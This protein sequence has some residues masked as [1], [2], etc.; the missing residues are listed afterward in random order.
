[1]QLEI[2]MALIGFAFVSSITPGPNNLMLL[3][4]GAN[5]GFAKTLPHMFGI[6]S[7]FSVLLICVGVGLGKMLEYYPPAFM[8]LKVAGGSYLLF[9]AY[10]IATSGPIGEAENIGKPMTFIQAA[11]FQWVNP[12]AWVMAISSMSAYT[13]PDQ[14][15]LTV[16]VI[17]L[18]FPLVN[19]PSVTCWAVFGTSMKG[20]LQNRVRLKYFNYLMASLL[21]ISLWPMLR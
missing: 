13:S 3:S 11:L 2:L 6:S 18:V 9:L 12:K 17:A 15:T 19:L 14:Y 7:G 4:S 16:F 10:K 20:F 5:F 1:M 21:V 8:A